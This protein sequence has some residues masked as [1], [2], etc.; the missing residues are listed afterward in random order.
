M[1]VSLR[2]AFEVNHR[3]SINPYDI[4]SHLNDVKETYKKRGKR[5]DN[6]EGKRCKNLID[7]V[8][9]SIKEI[10]YLVKNNKWSDFVESVE[11]E[12]YDL[13]VR[14]NRINDDVL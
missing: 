7:N 11:N 5:L 12:D 4:I 1:I 2:L 3:D 13:N 6:A 14:N 9:K 10:K 8:D